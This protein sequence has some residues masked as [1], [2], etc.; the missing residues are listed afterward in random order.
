[1]DVKGPE[2]AKQAARYDHSVFPDA[3][4]FVHDMVLAEG[5]LVAFRWTLTGTLASGA[6][7]I[8]EGIDIVRIEDGKIAEMWIE[9]H[10]LGAE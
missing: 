3:M 9:Y 10:T 8:S 2:A 1:M 6:E 4:K 5:N 7:S